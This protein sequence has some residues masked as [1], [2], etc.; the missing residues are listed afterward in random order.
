MAP[1]IRTYSPE[2]L[3]IIEQREQHLMVEAGPG[4]GKTTTIVGKI[5]WEL[6]FPGISATDV[7]EPLE[8]EQIATITFTRKAAG[9]LRDRLR[10]SLIGRAR[11]CTGLDRERWI[12]MS[13]RLDRMQIGTIDAFAGWLI[14]EFGALAGVDTGFSVM[15]PGD[16]AAMGGQVAEAQLLSAFGE[17]NPGAA[18]LIRQFGFERARSFTTEALDQADLLLAISRARGAGRT[19]WSR[20]SFQRT[21]A[22]LLLEPHANDVLD[23]F[24][25][26]HDALEK[27]MAAE[28][29]LDHVHVVIRAAELALLPAV[30]EAF[31]SRIKLLFVDEHQDT[32]RTQVA[33]LF[34]LAGLPEPGVDV[35]VAQAVTKPCMRLVLVGDPKQGIYSFR[36][37]DITM[38][39][40]SRV[41]LESAGGMY[42]ALT[43]NHR[44][45]PKLVR[46]F[47]TCFGPIMGDEAA[48]SGERFE[49]PYRS[50]ASAREETPET[51]VEVLLAPERGTDKCA[52][53][54]AERIATM[55]ANPSAYPVR[56]TLADGTEATRPVRPRDIAILSR[57]LRGSAEHY[58]RAL[59]ERG[60]SSYVY[61]GRGL[62]ARPEIQDV[63]RLLRA[64]ADAHDPRALVAFLRS[65]L[66]GVDDAALAELAAVSSGARASDSKGSIYDALLDAEGIVTDP[67]GRE[68][69]V[70][71]GALIEKL[72]RL[73]DRVPHDELVSIAMDETGYRAFLA[74][75]PD[76]PGGLRNIE[77]LLRVARKASREPLFQ[78]V[79]RIAARINRADPEEEA[80][81]YSPDDD[82]V[83]IST[84]HKAKGL[85]WPYVFFV[86]IDEDLF[87]KVPSQP[88]LNQ[89]LGVAMPLTVEV[90]SADGSVCDAASPESWN[91][92]CALETKNRYAEAKRLFFVAATRAQDRLILA[93]ALKAPSRPRSLT[94]SNISNLHQQAVDHWLRHLYKPLT[95]KADPPT[96]IEYGTAGDTAEIRRGFAGASVVELG[97]E[98][99]PVAHVS[100]PQSWPSTP[101]FAKT[102]AIA[103]EIAERIARVDNRAAIRREF[104]ASELIKFDMCPRMH[105]WAYRGGVSSPVIEVTGTDAVVN[106]IAPEKRG[107]IL[108][109][110]FLTHDAGWSE[111]QGLSEMVRVLLRHI[112]MSEDSA[113]E[114]AVELLVHAR[115]FLASEWYRRVQNALEVRREVPFVVQI[116]EDIRVVGQIDL[117]W[118][119]ADG[120]RMLDY[121][122][123]RFGNTQE[124]DVLEATAK[125]RAARYE[126]QAAAYALAGKAALPG[127]VREFVFFFTAPG[128]AV[129]I[130]PADPWLQTQAGR[131]T[132]IADRIRRGDYGDAPLFE[133]ERCDSC[134]YQGVCQPLKEAAAIAVAV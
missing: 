10:Q 79:Q 53:M 45:R 99:A 104:S 103:P 95:Q 107:D 80:P 72:R 5:E 112:P 40:R 63:A 133:H 84:I 41:A 71:A 56:M 28:R 134:E 1:I 117:M 57:S 50:M 29:V 115:H 121:K 33:L 49:V 61:G 109:D 96:L 9:E 113:R 132:E 83:P 88:L 62:Y 131:I 116:T 38:W 47:D 105:F 30:R 36:G 64:V 52:E 106:H 51:A 82:V 110:Y 43:T 92:A 91:Q 74:G 97:G 14:R 11:T 46:F 24:L 12:E 6:G 16:A 85:E 19:D 86:G 17:G 100:L 93:G 130:Q 13:C 73:R 66:G 48:V 4:A 114:N 58:E 21:P 20:F 23:F 98:P 34:R 8:L 59:R 108:H 26:A 87:W 102:T 2:Q 25:G 60:V 27:R 81:I 35:P 129:T 18:F 42:C 90:R 119:E 39:R 111:E 55:L 3:A 101:T 44:S 128:V 77:K 118:L 7:G 122:T 68:R 120:W 76:A 70:R 123:G 65:P 126:L 69:A 89:F 22:D 127:G 67:A 32:S 124:P 15:D 94:G 54:V 37:A 125:A 75:A 31:Q 78:F